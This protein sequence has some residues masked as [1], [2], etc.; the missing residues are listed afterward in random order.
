M[1][2]GQTHKDWYYSAPLVL[3]I[4]LPICVNLWVCPQARPSWISL[5]DFVGTR[6][7]LAAANPLKCSFPVASPAWAEMLNLVMQ[8]C[9]TALWYHMCDAS[10]H[11]GPSRLNGTTKVRL[12]L[13]IRISLP[14][15]GRTGRS[16]VGV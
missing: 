1:H 15:P 13:H 9:G 3:E 6:G 7:V 14:K 2:F 5:I 4:L 16:A 8:G 10:D 11:V 12:V